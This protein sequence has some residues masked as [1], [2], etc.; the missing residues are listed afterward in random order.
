MSLLLLLYLVF[1]IIGQAI[2]SINII[3]TV[4][5]ISF[6]SVNQAAELFF[7]TPFEKFIAGPFGL[8]Y[9]GHQTGILSDH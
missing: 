1:S 2:F 7:H 3:N 6:Q 4:G 8:L 5:Y 9:S